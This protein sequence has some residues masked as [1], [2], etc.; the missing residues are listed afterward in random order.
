MD[1]SK[2]LL[3]PSF[4]EALTMIGEAKEL[5]EQKR[6]HWTCSLRQIAK[7]MDKPC[8]LI[9]AR[10]SA[11]RVVVGQLHHVP[12]GLTPKTLQNH[13]SNAKAAL[14]WLAKE[15]G[16]PQHGAALSPAWER[17][18][19]QMPDP[20][21]RYRLT[22]LMRFC[23]AQG[24]D[25]EG[26]GED[27]ID[28]FMAYRSR[29]TTRPSNNASRRIL[30]R[31][32]NSCIGKIKGWPARRLIDPPVKSKAG[33][34]WTDFPEGLRRDVE[35]YLSGL[36]K[37]RRSRTGQRI[38]PAKRSTIVTRRRELA[39]AARMAV[40]IGTP[41]ESLT[42][43]AA[44]LA[45]D[46]VE[47]ILDAYWQGNGEV[48]TAFTIDLSCHFL[49]IARVTGCIN[50]R[51]CDKLDELRA[52]LEDHRSNGMTEKNRA[53]IRK[54]LTDG[55]WARVVNLP[56][57]LMAQAR[58][59][60]HD[61]PNRAAVAAQLAVAIAIL[62]VAPARLANL[63]NIRLGT[64]LFKP[65]GPDSNYWLV[66]PDYDVKN[67]VTLE[68]PFDETLTQLISEYV[69]DFRCTLLRGHNHDW[70]FPGQKGGSKEAI[71]FST[72]IVK[73]IQKGTGLRMSV[74]MFRH[75]C[76]ALILKKHPGNYELVRRVLGHK[77]LQT[78]V[79][80]YIGLETTQASEMYGKI[81]REQLTFEPEAA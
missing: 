40:K 20:S 77:R 10:W 65:G 22:P 70:L 54:V 41:I 59:Q 30:A 2:A 17:L 6:R 76:G 52:A 57:A 73:S 55:V 33:P 16:I 9:P 74:H 80:A 23:S 47:R 46:L 37:I 35:E 75:A 79:N 60:R 38:R 63:T 68:F 7:A 67:R 25:P 56:V 61:A 36:G 49:S 3:E 78:T 50:A 24:V 8:D 5:S 21:T 4:A 12:L 34:A 26:V 39:A 62:T 32:W 42:S 19:A 71:S 48:P 11:V 13:R 27:I 58:S 72:Q 1:K 64:N 18:K 44:L 15:T 45:P 69:H 28:G 29:S 66:F 43:L 31:L 14:L 51:D 53:F 81:V